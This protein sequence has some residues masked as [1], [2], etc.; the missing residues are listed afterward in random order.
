MFYRSISSF[1]LP[2][3]PTCTTS[4][5]SFYFTLDGFRF[6]GGVNYFPE[7][8]KLLVSCYGGFVKIRLR[9]VG[10]DV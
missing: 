10:K 9:G 4:F 3:S 6:W 7:F 5:S 2:G 1:Y 8:P